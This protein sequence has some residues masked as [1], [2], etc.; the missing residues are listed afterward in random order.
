MSAYS[1]QNKLV[2]S[3]KNKVSL[4]SNETGMTRIR[5]LKLQQLETSPD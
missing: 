1:K 2:N 3:T 5:F 4:I